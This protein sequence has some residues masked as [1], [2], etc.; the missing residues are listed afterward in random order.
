MFGETVISPVVVFKVNP[1]GTVP[2]AVS[3]TVLNVPG[4]NTSPFT[5]SF[6]NTLAVV[7]PVV[8][9]I[10]ADGSTVAL[11]VLTTTVAVAVSQITGVATVQI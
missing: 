1:A 10:A 11:I 9:L 2:T 4:V 8:P 7:P 5:L 3:V 6:N